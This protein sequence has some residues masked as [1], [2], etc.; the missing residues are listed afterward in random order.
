MSITLFAESI[1][2]FVDLK[3]EKAV[4]GKHKNTKIKYVRKKLGRPRKDGL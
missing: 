2:E 1:D 3:I 4:F